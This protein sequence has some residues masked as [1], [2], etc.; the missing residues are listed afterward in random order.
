[1]DPQEDKYIRYPGKTNEFENP[2]YDK[3][4]KASMEDIPGFW[5]K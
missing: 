1:M 3:E 2:A 4:F 5:K